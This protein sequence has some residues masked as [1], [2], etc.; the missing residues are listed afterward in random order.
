MCKILWILLI[1]VSTATAGL[2][3]LEALSLIESGD[4]DAAIGLVGEVSRYQIRPHL[5]REYSQNR[6]YRNPNLAAQVAQKHLASLEAIFRKQT[7][8]APADFDLYVLW[9][10]GPTYYAK[11]RFAQNRVS[12]VIQERARR[13][14]NLRQSKPTAA[15]GFILAKSSPT[16]LPSLLRPLPA[17]NESPARIS[18]PHRDRPAVVFRDGLLALGGVGSR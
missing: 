4:N 10:A 13:F 5:W 6:A 12:P 16:D 1:G 9:N 17:L 11:V 15:P 8:R 2:T 18:N 7:G 3:K 14:V